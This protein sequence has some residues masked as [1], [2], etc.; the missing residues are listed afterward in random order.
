PHRFAS[1]GDRNKALRR[2]TL[3]HRLLQ[4]LPDI[5]PER[6]MA[7]AQVFLARDDDLSETEHAEMI[8]QALAILDDVRFAPLFAP[9]SRAEVS[10][11][12]QVGDLEVPGQ[13]DRLAITADEVLIADY[14][15]NH[16][17]PRRIA[18]APPAYVRQLA[19]Y[20]AL[21]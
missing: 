7:A 8:T 20:R 18:D 17:A 1:R 3:L 6:R 2:G 15:T 12:G 4:S 21:L 19:L 14:K 5:V 10:V 13:I 9:G 11:A 16:P